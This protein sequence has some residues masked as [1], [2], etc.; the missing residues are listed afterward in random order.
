MPDQLAQLLAGGLS[1]FPRG[2][3]TVR[4]ECPHSMAGAEQT[5]RPKWEPPSFHDPASDLTCM[6]YMY[7]CGVCCMYDTSIIHLHICH[8]PRVTGTCPDS[9]WGK[10]SQGAHLRGWRPPTYIQGQLKDV[11]LVSVWNLH[12]RRT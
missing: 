5:K 9:V 10:A 6:W 3:S 7:V 12:I 2:L 11:S 1:S 8:T 4:L